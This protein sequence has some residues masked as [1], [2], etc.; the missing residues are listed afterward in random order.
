MAKLNRDDQKT[1]A[2]GKIIRDRGWHCYRWLNNWHV[3]SYTKGIAI[4]DGSL[5]WEDAIL[6][7]NLDLEENKGEI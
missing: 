3:D 7:A 5:S 6:N 4:V 2:A 1:L